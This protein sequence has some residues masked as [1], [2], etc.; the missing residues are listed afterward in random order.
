MPHCHQ[1]PVDSIRLLAGVL[2]KQYAPSKSGS[3]G[4][5]WT[6]QNGRHPPITSPCAVP[7]ELSRAP[8]LEASKFAVEQALHVMSERGLSPRAKSIANHRSMERNHASEIDQ[9]VQQKCGV[10][11]T[12]EYF[13][14][15][16]DRVEVEQ[17]ISRPIRKP[18]ARRK[19]LDLG[20]GEAGLKFGCAIAIVAGEDSERARARW[21]P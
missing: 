14:R 12:D 7:D 17:G 13:G 2:E 10:G 16:G 8:E 15:A 21:T 20:I 18:P 9:R 4:V 3:Y 1:H 5:Q 11:E 6:Q 19:S